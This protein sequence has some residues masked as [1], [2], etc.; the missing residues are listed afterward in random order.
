MKTD[1]IGVTS[2][3][4][5]AD[6]ITGFAE[7]PKLATF[8]RADHDLLSKLAE[9]V[10]DSI[11]AGDRRESA[12]AISTMQ[13]AVLAHLADEERELLP[14]YAEQAPA[15][16]QAILE[17]HAAIR[18]ALAEFDVETDLHLL[19]ADA[20]RAF[21]DTLRAHAE[22]ENAGLYRWSEA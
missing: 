22:R 9:T 19:R 13:A 14:S 11:V 8:L 1:A 12:D 3:S 7:P 17:D 15:D 10:L 21:L 20:V 2:G 5:A 18:R 4:I 6:E 16:A